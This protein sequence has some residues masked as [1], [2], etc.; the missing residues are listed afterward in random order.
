MGGGAPAADHFSIHQSALSEGP[1]E[2][3]C[4]QAS[5]CNSALT[6]FFNTSKSSTEFSV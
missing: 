6:D 5:A 3:S 2:V 4:T 1:S